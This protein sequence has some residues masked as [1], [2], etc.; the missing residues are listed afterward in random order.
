MKLH[1]RP[2]YKRVPV[3]L[4]FH[5]YETIPD[6]WEDGGQFFIE[7][8]HCLDNYVR[9]MGET[10]ARHDHPT[11]PISYCTTCCRGE[12]YLGHIPFAEVKKAQ[13]AP[14]TTS[15]NAKDYE[16]LEE[17]PWAEERQASPQ[18]SEESK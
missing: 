14:G 15:P 8:N 12:A 13:P 2:G 4:V 17:D 9:A 11:K 7:E 5:V 3:T 16:G 10:L 1:E 18:A 6:D